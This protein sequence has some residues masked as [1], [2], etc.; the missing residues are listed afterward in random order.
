[1]KKKKK[2]LCTKTQ[3]N[4]VAERSGKLLENTQLFQPL[5]KYGLASLPVAI[6]L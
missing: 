5:T 1:M 6:Y 3:T 2:A 4:Q